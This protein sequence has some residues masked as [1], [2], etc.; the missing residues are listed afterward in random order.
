[1]DFFL[2][3]VE[4][5]KKIRVTTSLRVYRT[6]SLTACYISTPFKKIHLQISPFKSTPTQTH[7]QKSKLQ[8]KLQENLDKL[9]PA[10]QL[11]SLQTNYNIQW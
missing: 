9:A 4:A 2:Q 6:A 1:M 7:T 8:Q 11:V 3:K 5:F 10:N